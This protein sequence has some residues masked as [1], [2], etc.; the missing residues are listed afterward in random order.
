MINPQFLRTFISLV[1]TRSFTKTAEA[2][3]MTQPGV[4]Q[5]LKWLEDYFQTPLVTRE[6][7]SFELTDAGRKVL[8]YANELF[9]YHEEFKSRLAFDDPQSGICRYASP[10]SFGI[11]MYSG[12]L[13]LSRTHP[14]LIVHYTYAPNPTVVRM[15]IDDQI[16]VGFVTKEPDESTVRREIIDHENLVI[17]APKNFRFRGFQS[18]MNLGFVNHPDGFHHANR[19]LRENFPDEFA[20]MRDI[21]VRA[22]NNQISRIPEAVAYGLGFTAL[23]ETACRAFPQQNLLTYLKL[24]KPVIDPVF[25]IWRGQRQLPSRFAFIDGALKKHVSFSK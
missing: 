24:P 6:H 15:L 18:L 13:E 3:A 20:S 8:S 5:H 9:H 22:F 2:L 19:L 11:K 12:L 16:D 10:G 7:R 17:I 23:P 14:G 25:Q 4:S 21:P 1:E